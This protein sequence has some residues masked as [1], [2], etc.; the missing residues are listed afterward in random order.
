MSPIPSLFDA[1]IVGAVASITLVAPA[2]VEAHAVVCTPVALVA[3][4]SPRL[5]SSWR[6]GAD[7]LLNLV[8]PPTKVRP[9][10]GPSPG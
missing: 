9:G 2:I 5:R 3:A 6:Q 4:P 10:S 8:S 1:S 7:A